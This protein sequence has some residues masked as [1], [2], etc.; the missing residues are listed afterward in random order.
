MLLAVEAHAAMLSISTM[1]ARSA[2]ISRRRPHRQGPQ[3][4]PRPRILELH[5]LGSAPSTARP[6]LPAFE[7]HHRFDLDPAAPRSRRRV[8]FQRHA[9]AGAPGPDRQDLPDGGFEQGRAAFMLTRHPAT[10]Q[11]Y[12]H[13]AG[14]ALRE[15]SAGPALVEQ[16]RQ[17]VH[18]YRRRSRGSGKTLVAAPESSSMEDRRAQAPGRNRS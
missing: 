13:Q 11:P 14:A 16:H 4:K 8:R 3:R 1:P 6:M 17:A 7:S 9:R 15:R 18:R 12:R 10:A 2:P 5:T